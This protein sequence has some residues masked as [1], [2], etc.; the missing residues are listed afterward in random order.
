MTGYPQ[1]R[2][3]VLFLRENGRPVA[4][5]RHWNGGLWHC[6]HHWKEIT[7]RQSDDSNHGRQCWSWLRLVTTVELL[8]L[9]ITMRQCSDC[10]CHHGLYQKW[11][12]D[13]N[14]DDVWE[15][16]NTPIHFW[17][18]PTH[19]VGEPRSSGQLHVYCSPPWCISSSWHFISMCSI[20][21]I[22][23]VLLA[24]YFNW[25]I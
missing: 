18:G 11:R 9:C 4:D 1:N 3:P 14:C 10:E 23:A 2:P 22:L 12:W 20:F 19:H 24:V 15:F 5:K 21:D 16:T 13:S 7:V 17:P 25:Y 6:S 8:W